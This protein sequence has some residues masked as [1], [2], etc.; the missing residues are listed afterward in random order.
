MEEIHSAKRLV[1][2]EMEKMRRQEG[3][4]SIELVDKVRKRVKLDYQ[5]QSATLL[6]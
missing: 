4:I 5:K 6:K 3:M 1:D 2:E